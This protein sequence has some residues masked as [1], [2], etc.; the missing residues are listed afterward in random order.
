MTLRRFLA[1]L[2]LKCGDYRF[3]SV[4][5]WTAE[6]ELTCRF[7]NKHCSE[8]QRIGICGW[9]LYWQITETSMQPLKSVRFKL[10]RKGLEQKKTE[11]KQCIK[12][13][14]SHLKCVRYNEKYSLLKIQVHLYRFLVVK[15]ATFLANRNE[16]LS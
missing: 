9:L 11:Y 13:K 6:Q 4:F 12:N 2:R 5:F 8:L 10:Y 15:R 1:L 7:R 14:W 16:G 3:F